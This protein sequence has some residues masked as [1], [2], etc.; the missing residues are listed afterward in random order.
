[1]HLHTTTPIFKSVSHA[2]C[3]LSGHA[4]VLVKQMC[5][6]PWQTPL[7]HISWSAANHTPAK[8]TVS[9]RGLSA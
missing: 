8:H 6:S 4:N 5:V 2:S 3:A 7:P 9:M 1:M